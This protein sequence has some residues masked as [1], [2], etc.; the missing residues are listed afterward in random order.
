MA[1]LRKLFQIHLI[2]Y[3]F[4]K[5]YSQNYKKSINPSKERAII[6]SLNFL[7]NKAKTLEDIYQNL[8]ITYI[9]NIETNTKINKKI[10]ILPENN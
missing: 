5:S 9:S 1:D 7:K 4:L 6:K 10:F 3:I 2:V 8:S